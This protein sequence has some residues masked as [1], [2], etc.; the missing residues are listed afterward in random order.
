MNQ[1]K[2]FEARGQEDKVCLLKKSIYGL[3]QASRL[4]N[5]TVHKIV[6][7]LG[8]TQSKYEPCVYFKVKMKKM[9]IITLYVDDFFIFSNDNEEKLKLKNRLKQEFKIKDLGELSYALGLRFTRDKKTNG[10]RIDQKHYIEDM[11]KKFNM[12]DCKP[13]ATPVDVSL[14][15]EKGSIITNVPYQSLIGSLMYLCVNTRPDIS[16]ITSYLSQFNTEHTDIHWKMAKRV[17]RYLKGTLEVGLTY[18]PIRKSIEG[19]SDSDFANN[20]A[21]RHSYSGYVFTHAGG[22][23]SW[24]SRKQKC[25]ALSSCEAEYV[26]LSEATRESIFLQNFYSEILAKKKIQQMIINGDNQSALKLTEN[27]VFH[28]RLKHI[29]IKYH[30]VR[31][32]VEKDRI[33][34]KYLSTEEMLADIFTKGLGKVKH[35]KCLQGLGML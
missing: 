9:T 5:Q 33:Q 26:A 2:G 10:Y 16:F 29:D 17:L 20:T 22:P 27:H 7:Q 4:W 18:K 23:I 3:K 13:A 21:D 32:Q 24:I 31:E 8:Y 19:F 11:L 15:K 28:D 12:E 34:L 30:F 25:I 6:V 35:N 1:P 14:M